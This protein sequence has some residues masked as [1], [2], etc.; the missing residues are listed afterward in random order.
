MKSILRMQMRRLQTQRTT[1]VNPERTWMRITMP[2]IT[3][4]LPLTI[5]PPVLNKEMTS[6]PASDLTNARWDNTPTLDLNGHVTEARVLDVYDGDTLTVAMPWKDGVYRFTIRLLGIDTEEIRGTTGETRE[7]ANAARVLLAKSI[8][9]GKFPIEPK[10]TRAVLRK[11]LGDHLCLVRVAC[12]S[13]DKYGRVLANVYLLGERDGTCVSKVL[14]DSGLARSYM[15]D[16]NEGPSA[17]ATKSTQGGSS[18][19][20]GRP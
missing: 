18:I 15:A 2:T 8:A 16:A 6:V 3:L 17:G 12:K 14:L 20:S 7:R 13:F 1:F 11:A 4:V 19:G 9:D 10:T 5:K